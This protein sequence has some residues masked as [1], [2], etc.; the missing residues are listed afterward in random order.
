MKKIVHCS[1]HKCLTVYYSRIMSFLY[2]KIIWNDS[3]FMHFNSKIDDFYDNYG[4]Y[5]VSSINNHCINMNMINDFIMTRFIR[6]PRDLVVSG[7]FYHL[8]GAEPWCRI[9]SP[10]LEDF[11][12]VNGCIPDKMP[13]GT[14]YSSYLSG[15]AKEDGLIAEIDFRAN[16]FAS[17]IGWPDTDSRIKIFRYEDMIGSEVDVFSEIFSF[18]GVSWVEKKIGTLLANFFSAKNQAGKTV[19]I[20]NS[21][22][23]Q[24]RE[25][26]TPKVSSYFESKY[27]NVLE[28]YE[29]E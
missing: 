16:H 19:H 20:R 15:L 24:W 22:S 21:K 23:K 25:H 10:K 9:S 14:S 13:S 17:M 3:R 18:Y 26:F 7:Y 28:K 12:V 5:R 29:Y 4:L 2:N 1:Y 11:K 6:D 27:A 8:R